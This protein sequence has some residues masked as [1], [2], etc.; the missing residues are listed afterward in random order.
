MAQN[1]T[2][3]QMNKFM[4]SVRQMRK[5]LDDL[6]K[7]QT[8]YFAVPIYTADPT[9]TFLIDGLIWV[10]STDNHLKIRKAGSTVTIV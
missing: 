7:N 8:K 5:E 6:K 1:E 10:N 9:G 4:E 3:D 2:T